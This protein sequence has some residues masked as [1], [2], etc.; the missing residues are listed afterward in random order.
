[1]STNTAGGGASFLGGLAGDTGIHFGVSF[2]CF[3]TQY[4]AQKQL[5]EFM[6]LR[7]YR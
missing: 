1:M 3:C 2:S 7:A 4:Y 5:G 6:Y